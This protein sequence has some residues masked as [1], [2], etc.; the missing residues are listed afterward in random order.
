M[1]VLAVISP[2]FPICIKINSIY[3]THFELKL[4]LL[5]FIALIYFHTSIH[6]VSY[7]EQCSVTITL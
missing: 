4:N 6:V 5:I 2:F 3:A 1:T 7:F